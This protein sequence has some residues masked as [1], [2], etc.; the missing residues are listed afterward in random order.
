L[1][2]FRLAVAAGIVLFPLA[3]LVVAAYFESPGD[4]DTPATPP[5]TPADKPPT[6]ASA[7]AF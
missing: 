1:L 4:D 5:A 7:M 3:G 6:T 2:V